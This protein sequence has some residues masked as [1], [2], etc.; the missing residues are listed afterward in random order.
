MICLKKTT[1]IIIIT[2]AARTST[3]IMPLITSLPAHVPLVK[4]IFIQNYTATS[5]KLCLPNTSEKSKI[6]NLK[7]VALANTPFVAQK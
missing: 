4:Q 1:T 5:K 2:A 3:I 6:R 7:I